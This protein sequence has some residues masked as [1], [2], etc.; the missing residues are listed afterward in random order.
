VSRSYHLQQT[1]FRFSIAELHNYPQI[2]PS[3]RSRYPYLASLRTR[4]PGEEEATHICGGVLVGP[5]HVLVA[6]SCL[7][8]KVVFNPEVHLGRAYPVMTDQAANRQF[9]EVLT[10][11][12]VHFPPGWQSAPGRGAPDLAIVELERRSQYTPVRLPVSPQ[13]LTPLPQLRSLGWAPTGLPGGEKEYFM[14]VSTVELRGGSPGD[15]HDAGNTSGLVWGAQIMPSGWCA[16]EAG[17]ALVVRGPP[18]EGL[19]AAG[20]DMLAGLQAG[21]SAEVCRQGLAA[22][23][24]RPSGF[25]PLGDSATLR[26]VRRLVEGKPSSGRAATQGDKHA[27]PSCETAE[28]Q[29]LRVCQWADAGASAA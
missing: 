16:P 17:R 5:S 10:T 12:A 7:F 23:E 2:D 26:W 3:G 13:P 29:S 19:E 8:D 1:D 18:G 14:D 24:P 22:L 15:R 4:L 11:A 9:A 21:P 6:A 20:G 28:F 27:P 25:T